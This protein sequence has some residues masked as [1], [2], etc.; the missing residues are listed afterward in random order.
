V[1]KHTDSC[2]GR[3][4]PGDYDDCAAYTDCTCSHHRGVR[5]LLVVDWDFFCVMHEQPREGDG[6]LWQLYDWGHSEGNPM[7][8]DFVWPIRAAGFARSG[9]VL[10]D[11]SGEERDFWSRFQI[12]SRADLYVADSNSQAAHPRVT[13]AKPPDEVWLY[14]AHHDCGY[15][16]N[17]WRMVL[18]TKRLSCE[19][20]MLAYHAYGAELHV[21]Y[22]RWKDYVFDVEPEPDARFEVDRE[23]DD[24]ANG[25]DGP[26]HKVF[27][28]RSGAWAPPW[29]DG[30]FKAFVEAAPVRRMINLDEDYPLVRE[31]GPDQ[32][33]QVK[34][35]VESERRAIE[36]HREQIAA[37]KE[38]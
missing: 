2:N 6:G 28:C 26:I 14:D 3:S 8:R 16:E 33:A 5:R 29:L 38:A 24:G 10:P 15:K 23:F 11:T 35:H 32:D 21:R 13:G 1:T 4:D 17:A 12:N 7:F 22:P 25:P 36:R 18:E 9:L 37:R 30:K 27:V 31:W 34:M 20:W 19:D